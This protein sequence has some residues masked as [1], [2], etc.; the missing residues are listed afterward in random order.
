MSDPVMA[1]V[2]ALMMSMGMPIKKTTQMPLAK[3][4]VGN[5]PIELGRYSEVRTGCTTAR[6]P[7]Y[8]QLTPPQNGDLRTQLGPVSN[9]YGTT[10]WASECS[11]IPIDGVKVTYQAR[12]GFSGSDKFS[13]VVIYSDREARKYSVIVK[14]FPTLN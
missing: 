11:Y 6:V 1:S 9:S 8:F 2:V 10:G 3:H 7:L 13:Y 14:V 4:A 5:Q 12:D